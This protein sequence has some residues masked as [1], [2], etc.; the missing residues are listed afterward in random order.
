MGLCLASH[1][2]P[3]S[4]SLAEALLSKLG[5]CNPLYVREVCWELARE[6]CVSQDNLDEVAKVIPGDLPG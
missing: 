5:V 2:L 6:S 4:Q 3:A 1:G